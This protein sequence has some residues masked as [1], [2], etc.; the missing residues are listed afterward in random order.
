MLSV[1]SGY[2]PTL[3]DIYHSHE[4]VLIGKTVKSDRICL[5]RTF[6]VKP[7]KLKTNTAKTVTCNV[8]RIEDRRI[9]VNLK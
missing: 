3:V 6:M 5:V 7:L 2:R 4:E 9:P 8:M 1:S